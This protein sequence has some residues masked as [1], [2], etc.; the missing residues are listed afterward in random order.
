MIDAISLS[1]IGFWPL[2]SHARTSV[3][4]LC[5]HVKPFFLTFMIIPKEL[6]IRD[7]PLD[8]C[9]RTVSQIGQAPG[10]FDCLANLLS[11]TTVPLIRGAQAVALNTESPY[12][13]WFRFSFHPRWG[14]HMLFCLLC[15]MQLPLKLLQRTRCTPSGENAIDYQQRATSN[16][17]DVRL[18]TSP[19]VHIHTHHVKLAVA[20]CLV[21]HVQWLLW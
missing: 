12:F 1:P 8:G 19:S 4:S 18:S 15:S 21:F 6:H 17:T 10:V 9:A 11:S 2:D 3:T 7:V 13:S 5:Y 20:T 14:Q 16:H